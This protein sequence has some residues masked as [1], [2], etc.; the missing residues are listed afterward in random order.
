MMKYGEESKL[1]YALL[2]E[3]DLSGQTGL[4]IGSSV[5]WIE[6]ILIEKGKVRKLLTDEYY[7]IISSHPK[8]DYIHPVD[9]CKRHAEIKANYKFDFVVSYSSLEHAGL[10]RF[11]DHLDPDGDLKEMQKAHCLLKEGGLFFLGTEFG[12]DALYW[13]A[14]RVY[15]KWR[16]P[17]MFANFEFQGFFSHSAVPDSFAFLESTWGYPIA[18]LRKVS[19]ACST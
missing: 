16:L 9:L 14:H 1:L 17:L 19:G 10:G 13:N 12:R 3:F 7:T 8:I 15:G 4:V 11:R 18:V 6:A 5:P 2:K